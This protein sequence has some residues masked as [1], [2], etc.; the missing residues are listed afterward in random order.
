MFKPEKLSG[1]VSCDAAGF[2]EKRRVFFLDN[3]R[4]F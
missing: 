1:S 2:S 3:D 4:A